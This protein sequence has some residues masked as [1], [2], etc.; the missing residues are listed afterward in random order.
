MNKRLK[1]IGSIVL[2]LMILITGTMGLSGQSYIHFSQYFNNP[3]SINPAFAGDRSIPGINLLTR[4]QWIGWSGSPSSNL[5]TGH[6]LLEDRKMGLGGTIQ[7]DKSGPVSI[8]GIS[9][10]YSYTVNIT[11]DDILSMG[12]QAELN[13]VQNRLSDLDLVDQGDQLFMEDP[14]LMFRPN[15]GLGFKYTRKKYNVYLSIPRLLNSNLSPPNSETTSLSKIQRICFI[16]SDTHFQLSSDLLLYAHI[17]FGFSKGSSLY[18][19]L[20]SL[21]WMKERIGFGALYRLDN[22]IGLMVKYQHDNQFVIGYSFDVALGL[23]RFN[24]GTHEIYLAYKLPF[25]IVE[26]LSPRKF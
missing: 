1:Y 2:L 21:V 20:S 23:I 22:T 13:F 14:G 12:L 15:F 17:L 6:T 24:S 26:T 4:Q 10:I 9:G 16:G 3:L 25:N 5:L 19:E 8:S 7:Y 18:S 11:D